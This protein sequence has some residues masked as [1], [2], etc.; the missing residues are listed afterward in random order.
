MKS[1]PERSFTLSILPI[2]LSILTVS[3]GQ[4]A[5]QVN[6]DPP[7]R[8]FAK[9]GG[10]GSVI[11]SGTGT[12]AATTTAPWLTITP[13]TSGNVGA[14]CIYVVGS[15]LSAD[16]RQG[17]ISINDKTHTVTQTGYAAT[18]SP[19]SASRDF[20]GGSGVI[21]ITTQAGVSW[22]AVSN[23]S[24]ITVTPAS[25]IS[26]GSVSYSVA[27]YSGVVTRSGSLTIAGKTFSV[28]QTGEA[29]NLSPKSVQKLYGSDIVQVQV[30]A[31]ATTL[32]SVTPNAPWISV[33]DGG[34]GF[35]DSTVT[36]AIS[37]NPSFVTRSG[38]VSIGSASFTIQQAGTTNP[39]LDLLPREATADPIG[40][41]GNVAVLATPDAPWTAQSLDSWLAISSGSTGVGNGNIEYIVSANPALV[42]RTGRIR[43]NPPVYVPEVDLTQQ[44]WT[45]IPGEEISD[46]SGWGRNLSGAINAVSGIS[47]QTLTG[48]AFNREGDDAF[49]LAIQFKI[50]TLDGINRLLQINRSATSTDVTAFYVNS[51]NKLVVQ[52]ATETFTTGYKVLKDSWT[53]VVV[54]AAPDRQV[55]VYAGPVGS[56]QIEL[57]GSYTPV[58]SPFPSSYVA[59]TS[60]FTFGYSVVPST[61]YL[62]NGGMKELR[63]YGRALNAAEVS[64]IHKSSITGGM[65]YGGEQPAG[66][67]APNVRMNLRGQALGI[68]PSGNVSAGSLLALKNTDSIGYSEAEIRKAYLYPGSLIPSITGYITGNKFYNINYSSSI[69]WKYEF[70]YSDGT[71]A[72]TL[73]QTLTLPSGTYWNST[74]RTDDNPYPSKPVLSIALRAYQ[75]GS[76]VSSGQGTF[77]ISGS[78]FDGGGVLSNWMQS[79]DRFG[80]AQRA[81]FSAGNATLILP[82]LGNWFSEN[83]GSYSFWLK[84]DA[85]TETKNIFTR[86]ALSMAVDAN[87][88]VTLSGPLSATFPS[89]ITAGKWHMITLAG[90]FSPGRATVYV[91]GE[92]IGNAPSYS[93]NFG[94][95]GSSM[96]VGDATYGFV[97]TVDEISFYDGALSAADV[98]TIYQREAPQSIYHTVT[99]GVVVP[100]VTPQL[101]QIPAAGG[102][103][104][105]LL[106]L[107]QNVNWTVSSPNPWITVVSP[108]QGAGSTTVAF[109]VAVNPTVYE[110]Q[111][112]I[113]VAGKT[114][115]VVQMGLGATV[116]HD[117]LVFATDGGSGWIEV[118]PEGNGQWQAVSDVSW[119]TVALG[120]VGAG[121]G[122]VFIVADP[123][124]NTS[125]SRTGTITVAGKKVYVTQRGYELSISPQVAQIGSNS[126]AGEFGVAAPL[127]SVWEAI[128]TQPWI[129]IIGGINGIG[130]GTVRYSIAANDS[131]SVRTGRI[132]VSGKEYTI[133]QV[134]NLLLTINTDGNGTVNGVGSYNTNAVAVLG[135]TPAN[136]YVFSHWSGDAVGS[137]NPLNLI[138]DS[139]KSVTAHFIPASAANAIASANGYVPVTRVQ[140]ERNAAIQDVIA[141]PNPFGL[142]TKTQMHGLALGRPVLE[143]N[144]TTGKLNLKLGLKH[145]SDL[146]GW[147]DLGVILQDVGVVNG[148]LNLQITPQGNGAFYRIETDGD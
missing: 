147:S 61:G 101:I 89:S 142:F 137:Q 133:T 122:S 110:R 114:V 42:P 98:R 109:D 93:Y 28:A 58:S 22:T 125:S 76:S 24:W 50:G 90:T 105:T 45:H 148:E 57:V 95:G 74:T 141:D 130:N 75:S 81:L 144:P 6:I 143:K 3:T 12:W 59:E 104:S 10:G 73:L 83:S 80:L 53:Q 65:T 146:K 84:F 87:G 111:G 108:T 116:Q 135:A 91:D 8:T 39:V 62:N 38:T 9:E 29:V 132:I 129:T 19:T 72:Q 32:W 99:Q 20:N 43:V 64:A 68:S 120:S 40:A 46:V 18:L 138:M 35:G 140:E 103:S 126:G 113:S 115:S 15:N 26:N 47:S 94:A 67:P 16:T 14:S 96:T 82:N 121:Q 51:Q 97:G 4:L 25:G 52:V 48:V 128:V 127:S 119:L 11:T 107:A 66:S 102:N 63:V 30:T 85:L 49:T 2:L 54:T 118:S 34:N 77:F 78:L 136:G 21:S 69:Y 60:K 134:S 71:R 106:T 70:E 36:L 79:S 17:V 1:Q 41:Y 56:E 131:G 44:L 13:R 86:G 123:Y 31:L 5:A 7:T 23:A 37:A 124:T 145:S 55:K 92:E 139:G 117:E 33:V 27:P 112:T 88:S 100:E